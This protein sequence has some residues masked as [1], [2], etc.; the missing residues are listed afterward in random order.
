MTILDVEVVSLPVSDQERSKAFY[1]DHLGL[2]LRNDAVFGDN[3]RWLQVAPKGCPCSIA[4]VTWFPGM[5]AGSSQGL[6][7]RVDDIEATLADLTSKGI[8]TFSGIEAAPWGR[9]VRISDPDGNGL[10]LQQDE[11]M[12]DGLGSDSARS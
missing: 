6:I 8:P 5:L 1:V 7:L 4:L 9:F 2:E 12:S 3:L 10:I 11:A